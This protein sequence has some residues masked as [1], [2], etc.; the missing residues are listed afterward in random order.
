LQVGSGELNSYAPAVVQLVAQS[1]IVLRGFKLRPSGN[2]QPLF[3]V[4]GIIIDNRSLKHELPRIGSGI[5][6]CFGDF[7]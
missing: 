1:S 6:I 7:K 2:N 4:D 3:I 5:D